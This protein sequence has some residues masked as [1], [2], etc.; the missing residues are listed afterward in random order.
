M[1]ETVTI[2]LPDRFDYA[3][4][5]QFSE[6]YQSYLGSQTVSELILDFSQVGYLDSAALGMMVLLQKKI[7]SEGKKVKIKGA[8]GTTMEILRMANMQNIFEFI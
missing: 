2:R 1:S 3:Y 7:S 5:R 4:H 6:N 8:R